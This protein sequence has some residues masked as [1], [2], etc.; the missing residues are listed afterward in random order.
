M[1]AY[2]KP[3]KVGDTIACYTILAVLKDA[4]LARN[5]RYSARAECCGL[6][7]DRA[8]QTLMDARRAGATL[9]HRCALQQASLQRQATY[10]YMERFGSVRVLDRGPEVRTWRV[11][12]DCCGKEAVLS[13]V[14]LLMQ[15]QAR[16]AGRDTVCLE[17]SIKRSRA[18][19]KEREKPA[20]KSRKKADLLADFLA[21]KN[22]PVVPTPIVH[23][24]PPVVPTPPPPGIIRSREAPQEAMQLQPMGATLPPGVM[25]A[26][27]A[28]PR[29][30]RASV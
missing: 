11:V 25:P 27:L 26:A 13:Q 8:E 29:P 21:R 19:A 16:A 22:P 23:P 10:G 12:W 7:V 17:C 24:I 6:V 18:L 15:R 2:S 4:P 3:L 30:G 9:C 1:P 28:W 20:R 5:R 14:Y